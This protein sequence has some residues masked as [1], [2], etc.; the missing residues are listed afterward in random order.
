MHNNLDAAPKPRRRNVFYSYFVEGAEYDND[1]P[2]IKTTEE[3]PNKLIPFSKAMATDDYN[4]W[5]CFYED[6]YKF[7][8]LWTNPKK[9]LDRLKKFKGAISPDFS[10]YRDMPMPV[11]TYNLFRSK[12][13]GY[14]LQANG[15]KVI[16]N[17]RWGGK[18]SYFEA[19]A[20][21]EKDKT[22]AIGS[23]GNVKNIENRQWL[24]DGL[25][26]IIKILTPKSIVF[27][28]AVPPSVT[29]M[30]NMQGINIIPFESY[31]SRAYKEGRTNGIRK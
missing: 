13:I 10:L 27:Y 12:A 26:T 17:V 30:A 31:T 5:V 19:C 1:M 16:P 23:H 25:D 3:L 2:I 4:Q 7:E 28:G 15:I 22:I 8:P 21:V 6:D 29:C 9:Y 18:A 20:G 24:N 14:W 11:Q